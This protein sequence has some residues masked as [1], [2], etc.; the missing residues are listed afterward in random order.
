MYVDSTPLTIK[1][2]I[3]SFAKILATSQEF[4]IKPLGSVYPTSTTSG[5]TPTGS[6]ATQSGTGAPKPNGGS[7][8][9]ASYGFGF[10]ALGAVLGLV[11]A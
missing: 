6:N 5:P 4:E 8:F 3:V 9:T 7:S 2:L 10:A 11:A 1:A